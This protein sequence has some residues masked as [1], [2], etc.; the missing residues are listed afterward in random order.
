MSMESLKKH[1][2]SQRNL[3]SVF[4]SSDNGMGA[5]ATVILI[6]LFLGF[7]LPSSAH[8]SDCPVDVQSWNYTVITS[9]CKGPQYPA[10]T[11]CEALRD[12]ACPYSREL[13][14]LDNNCATT[15]FSYINLYGNYPPGLFANTCR[16]SERGLECTD[17]QKSKSSNTSSSTTATATPIITL[18]TFILLTLYCIF[19]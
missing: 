3:I 5:A 9:K 15:M 2:N 4:H 7:P 6:I 19:L 14:D 12:L 13:N 1:V 16:D 8:S 11:C 17:A 10:K 18:L